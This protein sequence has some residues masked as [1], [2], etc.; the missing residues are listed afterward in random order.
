M[1]NGAKFPFGS[2]RDLVGSLLN[3]VQIALSPPSSPSA[4][5]GA[6][7]APQPG[8]RPSSK[9]RAS[10][11]QQA[12]HSGDRFHS[13]H[14][15][16][17]PNASAHHNSS[18]H[19]ESGSH[20]EQ[21]RWQ[22][23]WGAEPLPRMLRHLL[24]MFGP[25][26]AAAVFAAPKRTL[27]DLIV[28]GRVREQIESALAGV[29]QRELLYEEWN[30]EKIDPHGGAVAISLY[31]PSGTGKSLCAE[32]IAHAL[33]RPMLRVNY[34]ELESKFVGDTSKNIQTVFRQAR[35]ADAVLFFDEADAILGRRLSHVERG[36][37]HEVNVSRSV[38]LQELERFDGVALFATN[39]AS[40]YDPAFR[41]R[42]EH[43]A[44]PVPDALCRRRLWRYLLIDKVQGR[45]PLA[46]NLDLDLLTERSQGLTGGDLQQ[47]VLRAARRAAARPLHERRIHQNDL[48]K[49]LARTFHTNDAVGREVS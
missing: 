2:G 37:D 39:L 17:P 42:M 26:E 19:G 36:V 24:R 35:E 46:D 3:A 31:G 5:N 16:R 34:A 12:H 33:K 49:E 23:A 13:P 14:E 20:S 6:D 40:N 9:W 11:T 27:D 21:K 10:D 32:A 47:I 41:R 43:I 28:C 44:F 30:L 1:S 8:A 29:R 22:E 48:H 45:L 38:M 7:G 18:H 4:S 25:N 15:P